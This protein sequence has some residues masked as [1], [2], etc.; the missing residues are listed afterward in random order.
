METLI[1]VSRHRKC[2]GSVDLI[3][4][5]GD[6]IERRTNRKP[7]Y[8]ISCYMLSFGD[9]DNPELD[10]EIYLTTFEIHKLQEYLN[11]IDLSGVPDCVIK[12]QRLGIIIKAAADNLETCS[13]CGDN[14]SKQMY[15]YVWKHKEHPT[16]IKQELDN[17]WILEFT[18]FHLGYGGSEDEYYATQIQIECASFQLAELRGDIKGLLAQVDK[19]TSKPE[20]REIDREARDNKI[21]NDKE[22]TR[23]E[24]QEAIASMKSSAHRGNC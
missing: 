7:P 13:M 24:R 22:K 4:Y 15:C 23:K 1:R 18:D 21:R 14:L 5:E 2:S 19:K 17:Y 9:L 12:P 20:P 8:G 6:W 16:D 10:C 11:G 3:K